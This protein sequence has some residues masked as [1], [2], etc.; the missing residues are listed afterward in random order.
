MTHQ[1]CLNTLL[2]HSCSCPSEKEGFDEYFIELHCTQFVVVAKPTGEET[3]DAKG[4]T[5]FLFE[6]DSIRQMKEGE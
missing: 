2:S 5:I 3:L 4:N 1:E 6:I